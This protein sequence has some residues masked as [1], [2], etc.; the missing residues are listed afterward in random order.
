MEL[1]RR[2]GALCA[3]SV[4]AYFV[5]DGR[6]ENTD[7]HLAQLVKLRVSVPPSLFIMAIWMQEDSEAHDARLS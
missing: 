2:L 1:A 6:L 4:S 7:R 5:F 3:L